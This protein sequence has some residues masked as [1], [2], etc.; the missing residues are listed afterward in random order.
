MKKNAW[1]L[2][3]FFGILLFYALYGLPPIGDPNSAA[4]VH[5]SSRYIERGAL[6]TGQP[7]LVMAILSDYRSFDLWILSLFI[8]T[9]GLIG[10][11]LGL[12]KANDRRA[13][14]DRRKALGAVLSGPCLGLLV[15]LLCLAGGGNFLDYE[16]L[17]FPVRS[18][19]MRATGSLLME[20]GILLSVLGFLFIGA[21]LFSWEGKDRHER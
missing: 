3:F 13:R 4:W 6:E 10:L 15:G 1:I 21:R 5:V 8:L 16:S 12:G 20:A 14:S 19:E 17:S 2:T 9:L 11:R 18:D 7:H